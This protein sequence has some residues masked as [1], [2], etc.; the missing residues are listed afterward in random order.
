MR[1]G[2]VKFILY[3]NLYYGSHQISFTNK[4][5]T[6]VIVVFSILTRVSLV[7]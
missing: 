2:R 5:E 6:S 4:T 3:T 1:S 7:V